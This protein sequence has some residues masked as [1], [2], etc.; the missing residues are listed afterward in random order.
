MKHRDKFD[1]EFHNHTGHILTE[2]G[3]LMLLRAMA[4]LHN[5]GDER[6]VVRKVPCMRGIFI[7]VVIDI[8]GMATKR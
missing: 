5:W 7:D 3:L 1:F 6:S 8:H 4:D 2:S